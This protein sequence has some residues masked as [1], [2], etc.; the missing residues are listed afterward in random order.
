MRVEVLAVAQA[1][2]LSKLC[3]MYMIDQPLLY[4]KSAWLLTDEQKIALLGP[5]VR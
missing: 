1:G 3:G 4:M 5:V 2:C